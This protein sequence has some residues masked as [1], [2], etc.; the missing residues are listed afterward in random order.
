MLR[1]LGAPAI[2]APVTLNDGTTGPAVWIGPYASEADAEQLRVIV[3]D[4]FGF[5]DVQVVAVLLPDA[6]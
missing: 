6:Q 1:D 2:L 3:T 4:R 5:G